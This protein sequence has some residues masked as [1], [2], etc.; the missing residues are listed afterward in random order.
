MV[1]KTALHIQ[2]LDDNE[3]IENVMEEQS[4]PTELLLF[5]AGLTYTSK[6]TY[7]YD[8]LAQISVETKLKEHVLD[9][10][11]PIDYGHAMV[12]WNG[13]PDQKAAGW[14]TPEV[15]DGALWAT[16]IEWTPDAL[17]ALSDKEWRYWSPAFYCDYEE[18]S[19]EDQVCCRITELTNVALTNLPATK[20]QKPIIASSIE[21]NSD[22]RQKQEPIMSSEILKLLGSDIKTEA[23]GC[24]ALSQLQTERSALKVE[25]EALITALSAK[26]FHEAL[27]AATSLKTKLDGLAA[28]SEKNEKDALIAKLSSDG[29]LPPAQHDYWRKQSLAALQDFSQNLAPSLTSAPVVTPTDATVALTAT[30]MATCSKLNLKP[31]EFRAHKQ[32]MLSKKAGSK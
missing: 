28:S 5:N 31:E 8:Q 23:A 25:N 10:K 19:Y 29:K 18:V 16:K 17:K 7:L 13:G 27:N 6:G 20:K 26:N 2:I 11:C 32:E 4:I 24:V 14:F 9:G 30:E 1:S 21:V 3:V 22:V 15:R 12:G